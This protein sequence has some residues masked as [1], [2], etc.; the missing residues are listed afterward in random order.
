MQPL[1]HRGEQR[2]YRFRA[3]FLRHGQPFLRAGEKGFLGAGE[4]LG[5]GVLELALQPFLGFE[6]QALLLLEM[7]GIGMERRQFGPGGIA[8]GPHAGQFIGQR[9]GTG[10]AFAGTGEVAD[11]GLELLVQV[12][13]LAIAGQKPGAQVCHGARGEKPAERQPGAKPQQEG[14][15]RKNLRV[16]MA[17]LHGT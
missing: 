4:N 11:R 12:P 13:R 10:G 15:K 3:L 17:M 1:V 9:I 16:H 5:P 14:D 8:I 7:G 2:L 6:Q